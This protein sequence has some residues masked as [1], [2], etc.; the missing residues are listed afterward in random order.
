MSTRQHQ[1]M[2]FQTHATSSL[3]LK[4]ALGTLTF[5][6][7]STPRPAHVGGARLQVIICTRMHNA[8]LIA[9]PLHHP[10]SITVTS[11]SRRLQG[12]TSDLVDDVF[13]PPGAT[14]ARIDPS[15]HH[16][17]FSCGK[18]GHVHHFIPCPSG[19]SV[20]TP[21]TGSSRR[22]PSPR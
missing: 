2:Q 15:F 16:L 8:A 18:H 4:F 21:L 14:G 9:K 22:R 7:N 10:L 1:R 12:I 20:K 19:H 13:S 11:R 5:Y 6:R 17:R 3:T